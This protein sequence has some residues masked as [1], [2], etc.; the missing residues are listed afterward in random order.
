MRIRRSARDWRVD[1]GLTTA[2]AVLGGLFFLGTVTSDPHP[3]S[4]ALA[5]DLV[6][7]C[8]ACVALL[9]LRRSWPVGLALV[10]TVA[11]VVSSVAMGVAAVSVFG[12][13]VYRPWRVSVPVAVLHVGVLASVFRLALPDT[14]EYWEITVTFLA[15]YLAGVTSGMLVRSQRQLVGSLRDRA[16]QAEEQQRLRVEEARHLERE[17]LAREMHDVLAHRISLL[18]VHAG[19]LEIRRV[20]PAEERDAAGVIRRSAYQALEDL[21]EVI[22]ML[23]DDDVA[24]DGERP[25]PELTGLAALVEQ[26]E[27]AGMC[28]TLDNR[29]ADLSAIPT[30]AGRHVY[31]VIQEGLTNA[32]KH[33]AGAP[34]RIMLDADPGSSLTV[35]ITNPVSAGATGSPIPGAGTGLIGL[36]ER[37][38]LIGGRL[39][40]GLTPAGDHRLRAW[41]PWTPSSEAMDRFA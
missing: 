38:D 21:R 24:P 20:A 3:G 15:L 40:H 16:R 7:G 8:V 1:V 22:G 10:L 26:S 19:A 17:R 4:L 18:A 5:I 41:L 31:R 39:E 9:L 25:Q 35:E 2:A 34:V 14:R 13:A 28:V 23:R 11:P 27:Q 29:I 6:I 30:S 36:G 12:V 37:M 32:R 33:A